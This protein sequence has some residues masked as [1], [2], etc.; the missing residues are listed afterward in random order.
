MG[1]QDAA[2]ERIGEVRDRL[3]AL[4]ASRKQDFY[5]DV[6]SWSHKKDFIRINLPRSGEYP[7][8]L[9]SLLVQLREI[10]LALKKV[11]LGD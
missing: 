5:Q 1:F 6:P 11:E 9:D 4:R 3:S 7:K 2:Q 10:A 8:L